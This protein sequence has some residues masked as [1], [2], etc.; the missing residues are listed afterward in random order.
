MLYAMHFKHCTTFSKPLR[1]RVSW[2]AWLGDRAVAAPS[3]Q[4]LHAP[5]LFSKVDHAPRKMYV[6]V[7][8]LKLR[9]SGRQGRVRYL[10]YEQLSMH[11]CQLC[12]L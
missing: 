1:R 11:T 2:G 12:K 9:R 10:D 5:L 8:G 3:L 7:L 6:I 4:P